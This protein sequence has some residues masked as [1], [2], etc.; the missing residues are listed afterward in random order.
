M[1]SHRGL[2]QRRLH[3]VGTS[4]WMRQ[5]GQ[6]QTWVSAPWVGRGGMAGQAGSEHVSGGLLKVASVMWGRE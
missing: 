2:R 3:L 6:P 5:Y 4:P 1:E